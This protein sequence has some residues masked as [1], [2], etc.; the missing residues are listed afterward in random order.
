M[1][2]KR[3]IPEDVDELKET[4]NRGCGCTTSGIG[5][6]LFVYNFWHWSL[7][8]HPQTLK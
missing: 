6:F 4:H 2:K 1:N 7:F 3:P 5:F 8:I